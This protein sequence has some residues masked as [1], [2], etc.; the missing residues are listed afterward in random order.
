MDV[1]QALG[2]G[3]AGQHD[4]RL[5]RQQGLEGVEEFFLR[6][7]FVGEE[8]HVVDQQQIQRVVTLLELVEG[9][10]LVGLD[11][12]RHKLLGV[13][14]ENLGLWTI[15]QQV[16]A[17]GVHQVGLAQADAAVDEQRVVELAQAARHVHGGGARHAVGRAL[18]QGG[19]RQRRVQARLRPARCRHFGRREIGQ[20]GEHQLLRGSWCW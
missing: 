14:V 18:H 7:L 4:V 9:L 10:A 16:V 3:V 5:A 8:L 17:D 20:L 15:G 2:V 11:H 19:K 12:I 13:D 1:G 6:A